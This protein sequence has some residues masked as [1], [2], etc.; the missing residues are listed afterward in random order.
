M[1]VRRLVCLVD[2]AVE[3]GFSADRLALEASFGAAARVMFSLGDVLGDS[4][5]RPGH[6]R[7]SQA[8]RHDRS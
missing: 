6:P 3:E 7:L 8:E 2:Q 4:L 5:V 1:S